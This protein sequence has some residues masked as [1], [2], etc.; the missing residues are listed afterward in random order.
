V[1]TTTESAVVDFWKERGFDPKLKYAV[2]EISCWD[3]DVPEDHQDLKHPDYLGLLIQ[4]KMAF[5]ALIRRRLRP[6]IYTVKSGQHY[7]MVEQPGFER[8]VPMTRSRQILQFGFTNPATGECP[9]IVH[10]KTT[11]HVQRVLRKMKNSGAKGIMCLVTP[12]VAETIAIDE[13]V[14]SLEALLH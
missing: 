10:L 12:K 6:P 11:A 4:E 14:K 9:T 13:A 2:D 1:V 5:P 8:V 7:A 3:I